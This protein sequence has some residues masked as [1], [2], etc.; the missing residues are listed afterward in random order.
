MPLRSWKM[1]LAIFGFQRRVWCPKCTPASSSCF[2][3]MTDA[4]VDKR[5]LLSNRPWRVGHVETFA[6]TEHGPKV[7]QPAKYLGLLP[8]VV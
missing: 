5:G 1:Y 2:I 4:E 8:T 6:R 3:E 7:W